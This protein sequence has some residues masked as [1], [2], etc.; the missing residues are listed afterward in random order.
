MKPENFATQ[1]EIQAARDEYADGETIQVDE[2][3]EA[4][5]T[6]DGVWVQAWVFVPYIV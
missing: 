2:G 1:A 3:A 6:D 4:S 5:R